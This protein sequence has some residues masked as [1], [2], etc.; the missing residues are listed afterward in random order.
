M[1]QTKRPKNILLFG[2]SQAGKTSF[3]R[4]V[5]GIDIPEEDLIQYQGCSRTS[6]ISVYSHKE[7]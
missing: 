6:D 2:K 5:L 3:I 7:G 1:D 4:T